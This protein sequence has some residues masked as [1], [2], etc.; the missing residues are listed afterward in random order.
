[1]IERR[2]RVIK[3]Q[4]FDL[5][6]KSVTRGVLTHPL[7]PEGLT[8]VRIILTRVSPGGESVPHRDD[9]HHVFYFIKGTG[10]GCIDETN[11]TIKSGT[12]VEIPAGALHSYQN[13]S[14]DTLEIL[15]VNIPAK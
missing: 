12:V 10:K 3:E 7:L 8:N 9:Y 4:D 6:R 1:M 5:G 13:T 2:I 11:Y 15:V 14:N